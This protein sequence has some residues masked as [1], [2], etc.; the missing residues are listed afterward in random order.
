M[1]FLALGD[2]VASYF[3]SAAHGL[4]LE[5]VER[6]LEEREPRLKLRLEGWRAGPP[7][8]PTR[9]TTCPAEKAGAVL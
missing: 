1:T 4:A 7:P 3:V 8:H 9:R 2:W 5:A 6:R